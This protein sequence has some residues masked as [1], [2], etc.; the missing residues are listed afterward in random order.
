MQNSPDVCREL[1]EK[2]GAIYSGRPFGFIEREYVILDS[3]HF[4]F[5][6]YDDYQKRFRT[7]MWLLLGLIDLGRVAPLQDAAA[8]YFVKSLASTPAEIHDY[9]HN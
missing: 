2:R 3:Q 1:L 5:A 9:L 8:A 4:V 7:A 6:P